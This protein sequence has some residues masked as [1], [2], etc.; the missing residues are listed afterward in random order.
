MRQLEDE[1][2]QFDKEHERHR[3]ERE[4]DLSTIEALK[5]ELEL[6]RKKRSKVAGRES[7]SAE[8]MDPAALAE[9][10]MS[11]ESL[12]ARVESTCS[13]SGEESRQELVRRVTLMEPGRGGSPL[14]G[15]ETDSDVKVL[16]EYSN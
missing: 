15:S 16:S 4:R 8:R 14:S 9:P 6:E 2:Q 12:S 7:E 5:M 1:R 10:R 11:S 13:T 3:L